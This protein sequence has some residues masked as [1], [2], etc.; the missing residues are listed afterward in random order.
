[1]I[2][3][4]C[5]YYEL[6]DL[7]VSVTCINPG[8]VASEIRSVNN[9]GELTGK[10]DPVPQWLVMPAEK[11]ARQIVHAPYKRKPEV[12][13]TKHGKTA[14]SLGRHFPRLT[15]TAIR[16]ASRNRL[17]EIEKRKPGGVSE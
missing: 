5:L 17:H 1:M 11:A 8:F 9:D 7:G 6:S 13:L 14:V 3:A 12:V 16:L 4:G 15:R 2:L 10:P